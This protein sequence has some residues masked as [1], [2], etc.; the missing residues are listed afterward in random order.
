MR[1]L[2]AYFPSRKADA[3]SAPRAIQFSLNGNPANAYRLR[4][5]LL[6]EQSSVP[7]L[8]VEIN[9]HSGHFYLHPK[10]DYSMGDTIA[11]FFPAYSH[12][13]VDVDFPGSYLHTGTNTITLQAVA[14]QDKGVPE[15]GFVYDALELE[16]SHVLLLRRRRLWSRP[17][18]IS[19]MDK[20]FQSRWISS[21][22]AAAIRSL[23]RSISRS[24]GQHYRQPF[25]DRSEFGEER[26]SLRDTGI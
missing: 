21:F 24:A 19:S 23:D 20:T 22:D 9:G 8:R 18:F 11:A 4:V 7:A 5:S 10:L 25:R 1:M 12:A 16:L 13:D 14:T 15:A 2:P 6:I 3:A 17:S 26:L